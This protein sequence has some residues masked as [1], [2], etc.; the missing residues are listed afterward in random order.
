M[1]IKCRDKLLDLSKPVVMGILNLT[2][3]SFYDGGKYSDSKG[4]IDHAD[5]MI[6]NGASIIDIGGMSS[7]PGAKLIGSEEELK[8]ILF[9]TQTIREKY[10]DVFISVDTI[11]AHTAKKVLDIGVDIINDISAWTYDAELLEV[12]SEYQAAYI[13][14]HMQGIPASMQLKPRYDDLI[15]DVLRFFIEK[16]E[17]LNR[18]NVSEVI[19]DPGFGFGKTIDQNYELLEKLSVFRILEKPILSGLSRKSMFYK[20]LNIEAKDALPATA[21]GNYISLCQGAKILRVHDIKEAIQSI[22][23]YEKCN[24]K[25]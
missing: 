6:K 9:I 2:P 14:M 10:P 11:Y 8:R 24:L 13:L 15:R 1:V 21:I 18:K 12:V 25:S 16:I 3:D 17:E 5:Q 20:L 7:R 19:I 23:I 22:K 4:V